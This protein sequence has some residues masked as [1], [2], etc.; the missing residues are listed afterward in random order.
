MPFVATALTCVPSL[1][2][3]L[4]SVTTPLVGSTLTPGVFDLSFHT[5]FSLA[6]SI[7][8]SSVPF[9]GVNVTLTLS[10]SPVGVTV[11]VAVPSSAVTTGASGVTLIGTFTFSVLPSLYV[12]LTTATPAPF[13]IVPT[14]SFD[15]IFVP[16]TASLTCVSVC[17]AC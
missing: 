9:V 10:T 6:I 13:G 12:T 8:V 16:V 14:I 15:A 17:F 11:T 1:A 5:P 2:T 7:V 3:V 4:S